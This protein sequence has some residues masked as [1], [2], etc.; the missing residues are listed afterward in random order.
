[1]SNPVLD[2]AIK[3]KPKQNINDISVAETVSTPTT[4]TEPQPLRRELLPPDPYPIK[5]HRLCV[6]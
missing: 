2:A 1:M 3:Y 4:W 6:K 5:S